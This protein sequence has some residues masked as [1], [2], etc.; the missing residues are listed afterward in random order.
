MN[1]I[2]ILAQRPVTT[3]VSGLLFGIYA[4]NSLGLADCTNN[5]FLQHLLHSFLHAN[6]SHLMVNLY[7]V[8]NLSYL[9]TTFGST[10][11]ALLLTL[12]LVLSSYI[13]HLLGRMNEAG[14]FPFPTCAVGF[15]AVILGVIVFYNL[16]QDGGFNL[17]QFKQMLIL[18]IVPFIRN[19][20]TSLAGH[21]SG[22]LS[23][24][25][26]GILGAKFV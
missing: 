16:M 26:L 9:E 1:I 22:I 7:S 19:P 15:S 12:I 17:E 25:I 3:L 20:R 18:L 14:I 6:M 5:S 8:Y 13:Q 11:Y 10:Y 4:N 21:L 23:G 2:Q 24:G